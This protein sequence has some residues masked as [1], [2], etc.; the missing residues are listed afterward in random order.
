MRRGSLFRV[1]MAHGYLQWLPQPA[2]SCDRVGV[3]MSTKRWIVIERHRGEWH[4]WGVEKRWDKTNWT[5]LKSYK[6]LAGAD[7]YASDL[8][9]CHLRVYSEVA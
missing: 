4:V 9:A 1:P 2:S 8:L 7:R 5:L 6:T 3:V